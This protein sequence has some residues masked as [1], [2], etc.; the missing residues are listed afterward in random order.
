[1][2]VA[3]VNACFSGLVDPLDKHSRQTTAVLLLHESVGSSLLEVLETSAVLWSM[4]LML[5]GL[6]LKDGWHTAGEDHFQHL[7]ML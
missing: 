1:M 3:F 4:R 6:P 5:R 7:E 2:G